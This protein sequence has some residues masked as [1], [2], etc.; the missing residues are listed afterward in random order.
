MLVVYFSKLLMLKKEKKKKKRSSL[1]ITAYQ[2]NDVNYNL[3]KRQHG[4][5]AM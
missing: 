2:L 5:G 3:N 1:L 4:D